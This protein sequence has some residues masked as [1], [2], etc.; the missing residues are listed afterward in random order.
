MLLCSVKIGLCRH[1]ALLFK[2][3]CDTVGIECA[4]ITGYST[5][6]RH[7]YVLSVFLTL[8]WNIISLHDP[9][10]NKINSYIIDPTSPNFT[11]TKH[12][13]ARMKAYKI[14][15]DSSFGHGGLTLMNQMKQEVLRNL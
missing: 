3:L 11:W 14:T 5:G 8:R 9:K 10:E 6:G 1:K 12:G 13:S 15:Q 4:L 7:Q 2:I